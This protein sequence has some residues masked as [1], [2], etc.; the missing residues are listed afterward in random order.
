MAQYSIEW[1][2]SAKKEL[3]RLP[4][5]VINNIISAVEKLSKDPYPL[6]SKKL[7]GTDHT[8]R[9]RIGNYRVVYSTERDMLVIEIIRVGHRKDVYRNI[10]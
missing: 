3:K 4:K 6:G 5:K 1:K 2:S 8:Y 7:I 9:Y 10:T